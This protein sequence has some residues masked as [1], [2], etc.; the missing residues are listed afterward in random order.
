M[1]RPSAR[2]GGSLHTALRQPEVLGELAGTR[3]RTALNAVMAPLLEL[4]P[5]S[6]RLA[7]STSNGWK[8]GAI[9]RA[10]SRPLLPAI[11]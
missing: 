1:A 11:G 10:S 4:P 6:M 8:L 7:W 3:K 5:I 9:R 2:L